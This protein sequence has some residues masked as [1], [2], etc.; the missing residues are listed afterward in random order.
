MDIPRFIVLGAALSFTAC[1]APAPQYTVSYTY[2][3]FG[4]IYVKPPDPHPHPIPR[5]VGVFTALGKDNILAKV[6]GA[7]LPLE[8]AKLSGNFDG[9][10][11]RKIHSESE[12]SDFTVN[13]FYHAATAADVNER[14]E[15]MGCWKPG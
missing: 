3:A 9:V 13:V 2:G 1:S 7:A 11:E 14:L 10:G 4:S 8:G 5:C 6:V 12:G 15:Q